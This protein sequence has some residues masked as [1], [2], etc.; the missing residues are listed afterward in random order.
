MW[1]RSQAASI[2][3]HYSTCTKSNQET[4]LLWGPAAFGANKN[5]C[6]T[7]KIKKEGAVERQDNGRLP[8]PSG[9][10]NHAKWSNCSFPFLPQNEK[11]MD[12]VD[13]P[14]VLHKAE[15]SNPSAYIQTGRAHSLQAH[16]L[17]LLS[18]LLLTRI[19][20]PLFLPRLKPVHRATWPPWEQQ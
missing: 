13:F 12:A 6:A 3:Q 5:C 19:Q 16:L 18:Y 10:V 7:Y 14:P 11:W 2:I 1:I 15:N 8:G 9:G 17:C 4:N 20:W